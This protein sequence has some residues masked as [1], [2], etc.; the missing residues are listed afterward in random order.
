MGKQSRR[1]RTKAAP[2][3]SKDID[4]EIIEIV[5]GF[6]CIFNFF[7][8]NRAV[9]NHVRLLAGADRDAFVRQYV[10]ETAWRISHATHDVFVNALA[11]S[12]TEYEAFALARA[13]GESMVR[14]MELR[15]A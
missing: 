6:E 4:L 3:E 5:P 9:M 8:A 15:S 13:R 7:A 1:N 2:S 10:G 14:G 12:K 11:N